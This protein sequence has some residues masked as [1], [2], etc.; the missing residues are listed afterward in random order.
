MAAASF[1]VVQHGTR[2]QLVQRRVSFIE[3]HDRDGERL[4]VLVGL[5]HN[6][7]A[8]DALGILETVEVKVDTAAVE[9]VER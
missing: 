9:W 4:G 6:L 5:D 1:Q 7:N 8:F 2:G 3:D